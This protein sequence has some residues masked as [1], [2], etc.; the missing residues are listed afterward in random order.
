MSAHLTNM[1]YEVALTCRVIRI[2]TFKFIS[3]ANS[4]VNQDLKANLTLCSDSLSLA[5]GDIT[6]LEVHSSEIQS[7]WTYTGR[8][9][10]KAFICIQLKQY[11]SRKVRTFLESKKAEFDPTSDDPSKRF[12]ALFPADESIPAFLCAQ[13]SLPWLQGKDLSHSQAQELVLATAGQKNEVSFNMDTLHPNPASTSTKPE[14]SLF[15]TPGAAV[16]IQNND[17]KTISLQTKGKSIL[18]EQLTRK[19]KD[20]GK[21]DDQS[22]KIFKPSSEEDLS[23]ALNLEE[24]GLRN[25][26]VSCEFYSSE[27]TIEME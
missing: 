21:N 2:G 22:W 6:P 24:Q 7:I 8:K 25:D 26:L 11:S 14:S 20:S 16:I 10:P 1:Y 3:A 17:I 9:L 13:E 27:V 19:R 15:V 23:S 12:I 18:K 4:K 5:L